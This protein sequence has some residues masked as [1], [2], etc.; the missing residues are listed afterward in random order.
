MAE[1][2]ALPVKLSARNYGI[3]NVEEGCLD[4]F[5]NVILIQII[6]GMDVIFKYELEQSNYPYC[7][8]LLLKALVHRY[9]SVSSEGGARAVHVRKGVCC[10][11]YCS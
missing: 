9:C 6:P 3:T 5:V 8:V 11:I 7:G 10:F 2:R 4:M 1:T